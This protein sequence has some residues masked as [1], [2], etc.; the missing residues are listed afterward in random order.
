MIAVSGNVAD[1]QAQFREDL[2]QLSKDVA[3]VEFTDS[4]LE[5][6][7]D[8]GVNSRVIEEALRYVRN[9]VSSETGGPLSVDH[10]KLLNPTVMRDVDRRLARAEAAANSMLNSQVKRSQHPSNIKRPRVHSHIYRPDIWFAAPPRCNVLFPELYDSIQFQR[11]F[12]R[13]VTRLEMQVTHFILGEDRLLNQRYYAPNVRDMR[14]GL[15]LSSEKFKRLTMHH[16]LL[17]GIIPM[18]ERMSDVNLYSLRSG[19]IAEKGGRIRYAQRAANF[20]YFKHRFASRSASVRGRFNPW[21]A[22][23]FPM[24]VIDRPMT[25]DNL[26]LSTLPLEEQLESPG[27][28]LKPRRGVKITRGAILRELVGPQFV[29]MCSQVTH[30]I[31]QQGGTTNYVMQQA[32]VHREDMEYV[33]ADKAKVSKTTGTLTKQSY[34]SALPS[35]A[36]KV[37]MKG[38]HG[39]VI[40]SVFTVTSQFLGTSLTHYTTGKFEVVGFRPDGTEVISTSVANDEVVAKQGEREFYEAYKII[41]TSKSTR[42][43]DVDLPMEEIVKPYWIWDG[44]NNL[45]IGDTY[46]QLLGINSLTDVEG[47][48]KRESI[49]NV[50]GDALQEVSRFAQEALVHGSGHP[51]D[52]DFGR[53]NAK[54][55]G[56]SN[57]DPYTS[58][59][60]LTRS[61]RDVR[62]NAQGVKEVNDRNLTLAVQLMLETDRT[63]ESSIDQLV[64]IYSLIAHEKLDVAGFIRNYTW[65]PVAT[66]PQMLGTR[67]LRLTPKANGGARVSE[68][69]EG[70][71][72]RAFSDYADLFGLVNPKVR[73]VLGLSKDKRQAVA[74]NLDVRPIRRQAVRKYVQELAETQG[75]LG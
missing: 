50:I 9:K 17:T 48:T 11:N 21:V 33:G 42:K 34:V 12:L 7:A 32:R 26:A 45:R 64:R 25:A 16:E 71:H 22:P 72:S 38:V 28:T 65:R 47:V 5:K 29:G 59:Q 56:T 67:D 1:A 39:G 55:S 30:D 19:K 54:R 74:D 57:Q 31:N 43:V 2:N 10:F 13:E 63:V 36:P 3:S 75:L 14:R 60:Q 53:T 6:V 52:S 24:L 68:G 51:T 46:M 20:Q 44:W 18:F 73:K 27:I 8:V 37:G 41:E 62:E 4:R 15:K 40:Q 61:S 66:L 69:K 49:A 70:F 35:E 23:G 58:S